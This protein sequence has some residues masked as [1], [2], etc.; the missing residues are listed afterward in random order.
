MSKMYLGSLNLNKIDKSKIVTTDKNGVPFKNGAKYLN[1]VVFINDNPDEYGNNASI[2]LSK[3][4]GENSIY[5]GNLKEYRRENENSVG[6][7][8]KGVV[9]N[10]NEDDL[11]F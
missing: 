8:D 5:I 10:S 7:S 4:E 11:P 9:D 3:K 6:N 2:Q 1:I